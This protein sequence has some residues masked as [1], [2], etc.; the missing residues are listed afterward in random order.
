MGLE[1]M[2]SIWYVVVFVLVDCEMGFDVFI[3]EWVCDFW[4]VEVC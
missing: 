1:G 2:F 4:L 3:D